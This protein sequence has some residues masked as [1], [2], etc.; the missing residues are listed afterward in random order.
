MSQRWQIGDRARLDAEYKTHLGRL[1]ADTPGEIVT[2][3]FGRRV[4]LRTASGDVWI[5]QDRL[6]LAQRTMEEGES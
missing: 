2:L 1:P 5:D 6:L 4:C 3:G